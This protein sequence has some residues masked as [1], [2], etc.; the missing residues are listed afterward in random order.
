MKTFI[1]SDLHFEHANITKFCP[2]TRSRFTDVDH[3]RETMIAEWNEIVAPTDK[4]YILGDV[5]FCNADKATEIINRLNGF[6]I[7]VEGNH[8]QKL[9]KN[10]GFRKCFIEIHKYLRISYN[11][12]LIIM[13]HYPFLEWDQMHRGSLHFFGHLHGGRTGQEQYRCK[14]VGYD[15][16]GQIVTLME[17]AIQ[18]VANNEIKRH[19]V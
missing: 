3:M 14:D 10:E 16:T 5:A 4:V 11:G 18:S 9:L 8:D 2:T 1:T 7:L 13:S 6:K 15:A 19:H 17:D 12:T